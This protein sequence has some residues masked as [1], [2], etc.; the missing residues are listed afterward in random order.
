MLKLLLTAYV[1]SRHRLATNTRAFVNRQSVRFL[2]A[3]FQFA[4]P[5]RKIALLFF[6]AG[7]LGIGPRL[8]ASKA[9]VLPLDDLPMFTFA[10]VSILHFFC[11]FATL[12][13]DNIN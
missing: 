9:P 4:S 7:R 6:R 5:E 2:V 1:W 3:N 8:R 13:T 12:V 10:N 11:L